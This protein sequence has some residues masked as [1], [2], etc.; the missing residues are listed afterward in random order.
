MRESQ[1]LGAGRR[2]L[3]EA[4]RAHV[5]VDEEGDIALCLR[6]SIVDQVL[7]LAVL[8]ARVVLSVPVAVRLQAVVDAVVDERLVAHGDG[9]PL[10]EADVEQVVLRQRYRLDRV[11]LLERQLFQVVNLRETVEDEE[12]VADWTLLVILHIAGIHL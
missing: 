1:V 9:R 10:D 5:V 8:L 7:P 12:R 6:A 11:V 2:L 3:V 4:E